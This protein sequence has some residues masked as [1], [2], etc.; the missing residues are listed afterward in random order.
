MPAL[1]ARSPSPTAPMP[2]ARGFDTTPR[3]RSPPTGSSRCSTSRSRSS[4]RRAL[5]GKPARE[6]LAAL[7]TGTLAN[8]VELGPEGALTGPIARGDSTV[9]AS[10]LEVLGD[11]HEAYRA[12]GLRQ[13]ELA[14]A[15]GSLDL[16][17]GAELRRLLGPPAERP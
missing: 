8:L 1:A 9:V 10:H 12:L 7:C 14:R 13:V 6:A 11:G 4:S 2:M 17:R 16:R 15:R 5:R 3:R